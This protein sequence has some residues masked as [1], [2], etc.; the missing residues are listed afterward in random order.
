MKFGHFVKRHP[1]VFIKKFCGVRE[2]LKF[3]TQA[4]KASVAINV[5]SNK[6]SNSR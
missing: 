3:V 2:D 6:D 5:S 4:I 1:M